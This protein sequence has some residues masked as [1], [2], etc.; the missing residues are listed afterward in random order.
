MPITLAPE[1]LIDSQRDKPLLSELLRIK[2]RAL[3]LHRPHRVANDYRRI[4]GSLL[5]IFG[6][7]QVPYNLHF[8]LIVKGDL[9][10]RYLIAPVKVI[11]AVR[12][13]GCHRGE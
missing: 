6:H 2:V 13:I 4:V 3:L 9:L 8:E 12:H 7:V 10:R 5:P 1:R 11:C